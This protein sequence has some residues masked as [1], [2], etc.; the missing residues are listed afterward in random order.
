MGFI[1]NEHF[2]FFYA[3][4]CLA[5]N[6]FGYDVLAILAYHIVAL[7][8]MERSSA[9]LLPATTTKNSLPE[10]VKGDGDR[11]GGTQQQRRGRTLY[12]VSAVCCLYRIMLLCFSCFAAA[13]HRRHLMVW[14]VFAPKVLQY[15]GV[16]I[17]I[18]PD[19]LIY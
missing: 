13:L 17:T 7:L 10:R 14:A 6:T 8:A 3:G 4:I 2:N 12:H 18:Y 5:I 19:N 15:S 16:T 11:V 1:G 9:L